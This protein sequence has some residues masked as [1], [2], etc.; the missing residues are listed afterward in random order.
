MKVNLTTIFILLSINFFIHNQVQGWKRCWS[1][2]AGINFELIF[3][4]S[5]GEG[6]VEKYKIDVCET[7]FS[8]YCTTVETIRFNKQQTPFTAYIRRW[9]LLSWLGF[10]V[11]FQFFY[12][13][14]KEGETDNC[15]RNFIYYVSEDCYLCDWDQYQ[16]RYY[17]HLANASVISG[18][19]R[20]LN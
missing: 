14:C 18:D 19:F 10:D 7:S 1:M 3:Q 20:R 9:L 5:T 8:Y 6:Y 2:Q 13:C 4:C 15:E 17:I 16:C 12:R 11:R